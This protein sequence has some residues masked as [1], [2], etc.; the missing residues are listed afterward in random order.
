M[1]IEDAGGRTW[2][3]GA[4]AGWA[5][6]AWL[7]ALAGMAGRIAPLPDDPSLLKP[8][9]ALP[10]APAERLG[11]LVQ[12]GEIGGRPLFS[13]D[14]QPRPFLL[15]GEADAGEAV[16]DYVL[17]SVLITP[18]LKLAIL[19][20]ADGS[21]SVRVKLDEAPESHPAWR[22]SALG[23]RSAVFEGPEGQ[24][25]MEL[26]VFDGLGGQSPTARAPVAGS[27]ASPDRQSPIRPPVTQPVPVPRP[28]ASVGD[29]DAM[30]SSD[31]AQATES[32]PAPPGPSPAAEEPPMTD[33]SQMEAIRQR[34]QARRAQLRQ[35]NQSPQPP[36]KS[37]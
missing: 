3:L 4:A 15:Q 16:F 29:A 33:Q 2:L 17:T 21:E 35:Q 7:L 31:E 8:L 22:L 28:P 13:Q 30:A 9:P 25:T 6:A 23:A 18:G 12:Y 34:I 26:R 36:A 11:P 5:L 20:P 19:Q 37:P 27:P 14:R 1:R 10:S 24:R 32:V